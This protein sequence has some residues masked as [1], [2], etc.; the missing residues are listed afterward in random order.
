VTDH[1]ASSTISPRRPA[2]RSPRAVAVALGVA[3]FLLAVDLVSKELAFQHVAGQ[4]VVLDANAADPDHPV[5]IIPNH[6]PTIVIPKVLALQLTLNHG[7]VFGLGQGWR[8]IF[9]LF[10]L[11]AMG[12]LGAIFA[13]SGPRST[14][15]HI[16]LAMVLAG[17]LGNLYDRIVYGAVRDLLL[18]FPGVSLPFG[19]SWPDGATGLYPWIFNLADVCL[20]VGLLV[21]MVLSFRHDAAERRAEREAKA[22]RAAADL[23]TTSAPEAD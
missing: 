16:A 8:W 17:A 4:P 2:W 18:L 6:E 23:E 5:A 19:W 14:V 12:V 3:V 11:L 13:R 20:V 21:L 22:G 7:A 9:V 15:L 10:S 1:P